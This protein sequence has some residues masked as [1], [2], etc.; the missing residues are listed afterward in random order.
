MIAKCVSCYK[1]LQVIEE[2]LNMCN[3][4]SHPAVISEYFFHILRRLSLPPRRRHFSCFFSL[5]SLSSLFSPLLT[6]LVPS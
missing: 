3:I 1:W 4:I 5:Y 2:V 6:I